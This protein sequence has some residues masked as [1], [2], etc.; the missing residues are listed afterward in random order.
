MGQ[1]TFVWNSLET[2]L[3]FIIA[4]LTETPEPSLESVWSITQ[5]LGN[6]DKTLILRTLLRTVELTDAE[7]DRFDFAVA[8]YSVLNENRNCLVHSHSAQIG[9]RGSIELGRH[10]KSSP[11]KIAMVAASIADL[12]RQLYW[13]AK[14]SHFMDALAEFSFNRYVSHEKTPA[15]PKKFGMPRKLRQLAP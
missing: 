9:K 8:A 10:S 2:L 11:G 13:V 3:D 14:L 7:R 12:K 4:C 15:L 1:I 5:K 6:R